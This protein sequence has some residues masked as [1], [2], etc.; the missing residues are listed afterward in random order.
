MM[1]NHAPLLDDQIAQLFKTSVNLFLKCLVTKNSLFQL[2]PT[3]IVTRPFKSNS[4]STQP[5]V[6]S[7]GRDSRGSEEASRK[8]RIASPLQARPEPSRSEREGDTGDRTPKRRKRAR[9]GDD[10]E[11]TYLRR[12]AQDELKENSKLTIRQ[13]KDEDTDVSSPSTISDNFNTPRGG[14]NVISKNETRKLLEGDDIPRHVEAGRS[15]E[16]LELQKSART[17]FFA[18]VSNEAVTSKTARKSL[19]KHLI[20]F[21]EADGTANP[22]TVES[23]RFRSTPFSEGRL[24]RKAAYAKKDIMSATTRST[25]A[26]A[27]YNTE[28]VALEAARRLNGTVVLNRHLRADHITRPRNQDHRKCVFVGNLGFVDDESNMRE[29][30]AEPAHGS[31]RRKKGKHPADHEEGLWRTFNTMGEVESVR[32][33]RD[34][35]TQV[36]KGFAYVQFKVRVIYTGLGRSLTPCEDSNAVEKALLLNE[37]MFPPMLPRKLRVVR[38]DRP[39]KLQPTVRHDRSKS[40]FSHGQAALPKLQSYDRTSQLVGRAKAAE[41][42]KRSQKSSDDTQAPPSLAFEGYRATQGSVKKGAR[43]GKLGKP[44]NRSS[45]RG[46]DF[47]RR[48]EST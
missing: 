4:N 47:K 36:G 7:S 31:G 46:A 12:L 34:K 10:L 17:V 43:K 13:G 38:A 9:D 33:I 20:S 24:P 37:K 42:G 22:A 19:L 8:K 30:E 23:L 40:R 45:R 39:T 6:K 25:H 5:L 11:T 3:K 16:D 32:M 18:N 41:L 35:K 21:S 14:G 15:K 29:A 1:D 26:Y 28:R 48:K 27:I 2:G 44:Q